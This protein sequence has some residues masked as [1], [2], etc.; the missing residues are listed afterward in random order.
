MYRAGSSFPFLDTTCFNTDGSIRNAKSGLINV[1]VS[2]NW[3]GHC[4]ALKPVLESFIGEIESSDVYIS[5]LDSEQKEA[6]NLVSKQVPISHFPTILRFSRNGK[7]EKKFSG[8]T[9]DRNSLKNFIEG[10]D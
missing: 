10:K 4:K 8:R 5:I 3:C 9:D 6:I 7:F 1:V 2:A